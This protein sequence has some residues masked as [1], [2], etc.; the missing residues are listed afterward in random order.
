MIRRTTDTA[1]IIVPAV[2][3]PRVLHLASVPP[4]AAHSGA[5]KMPL[6]ELAIN[7][8]SPFQKAP[9]D[10]T[11]L[12]VITDRYS[13]LTR[14]VP[15]GVTKAWELAQAFLNNWVFTYGLPSTL[16]SDSGPPF[17]S[18][19]LQAAYTAI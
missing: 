10:N 16:L 12:L 1:Q 4:V 6:K 5:R 9:R 7:L 17:D 15:M 3:R 14:T 2:L 13:K 8:L 11:H 19:L 18:K